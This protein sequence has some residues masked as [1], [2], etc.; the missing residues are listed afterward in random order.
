MRTLLIETST[1]RGVIAIAESGILKYFAGLPFGYQNSRFLVPKIDEALQLLQ[2]NV[3]Q[4]DLIAV[5]IGPGSYTG[6]RVA[7]AVAKSLSFPHKIP[8]VGINTMEGFLPTK[9][10]HFAVIFDAKL[11]GATVLRG[12]KKG[13]N[14]TYLEK[15][16][17]LSLDKLKEKL[18]NVKILI[19]PN[20]LRLKEKL[21]SSYEWEETAPDPLRMVD[22][23]L[24]KH[25]KGEFSTDGS[26]EIEYSGLNF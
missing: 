1:E 18:E 8:L 9:E 13:Q 22:L 21:S 20:T 19:S 6:T 15:P 3:D 23:A 4:L 11:S 2:I 17:V 16:E 26:L 14:I 10:G 5:G 7:V 25:E 12:E 24:K